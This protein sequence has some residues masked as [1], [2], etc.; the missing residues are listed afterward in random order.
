[1]T[2]AHNRFFDNDGFKFKISFACIL[3]LLFAQFLSPFSV[4]LTQE[5]KSCTTSTGNC[6]QSVTMTFLIEKYVDFHTEILKDVN[7]DY[8][9]K[10]KIIMSI[11][12]P[13]A[14][15]SFDSHLTILQLFDRGI[16]RLQ[17]TDYFYRYLRII[18]NY[19]LNPVVSYCQSENA[20]NE[21]CCGANKFTFDRNDYLLFYPQS[22]NFYACFLFSFHNFSQKLT[23]ITKKIYTEKCNCQFCCGK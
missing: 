19:K 16:N 4:L 13:P 17:K 15:I 21:F 14:Q 20:E 22:Q 2:V 10:H 5:L 7:S 9:Y 11:D 23:L 6:T 18:K 8:A 1:M 3:L 12:V